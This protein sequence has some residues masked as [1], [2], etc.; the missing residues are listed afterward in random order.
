MQVA[1]LSHA[2]HSHALLLP[3]RAGRSCPSSPEML[4]EEELATAQRF[5][6][7]Y[8]QPFPRGSGHTKSFLFCP[9]MTTIDRLM[10]TKSFCLLLQLT[11]FALVFPWCRLHL[12]SN[13]I[14]AIVNTEK[15]AA[16]SGFSAFTE[17]L[18]KKRKNHTHP[19]VRE[20][21]E[22]LQAL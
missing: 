6:P 8:P 19:F 17:Q 20:S 4:Y 22:S 3:C 10:A 14:N 15:E 13:M 1:S 2:Q 7:G 5:T 16:A 11:T 21:L 9:Q 12:L 18:T